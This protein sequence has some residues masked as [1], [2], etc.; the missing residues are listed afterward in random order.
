MRRNGFFAAFVCGCVTLAIGACVINFASNVVNNINDR[1][2]QK[3][4]LMSDLLD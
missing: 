3:V 1:Q 4:E 2:Q